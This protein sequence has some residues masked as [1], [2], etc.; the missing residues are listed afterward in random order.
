[1]EYRGY[2]YLFNYLVYISCLC[3]FD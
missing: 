3:H 1:M 2:T